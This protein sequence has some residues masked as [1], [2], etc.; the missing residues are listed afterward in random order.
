M[1]GDDTLLSEQEPVAGEGGV[2]QSVSR[3]GRAPWARRYTLVYAWVAM[4]IVYGAIDPS[5]FLTAINFEVIFST[6]A[7]LLILCLG[8]LPSLA[9]G[10]IDLS[11]A[12]TFGLS[13]VLTA[14]LNVNLGMPIGVSILAALALGVLV[15][16]VN[17]LL[18]VKLDVGSLVVTLGMS[19]L[20]AGVALGI[21]TLPISGVSNALVTAAGLRLAGLQLVFFYAVLVTLA[22][23][24]VE[25]FTPLGRYLFFVGA[26][27][28]VSRLSGIPV[29]GLRAG[30]LIAG[31]L[32]ASLAGVLL[33][34]T[35]GSADPTVGPTYLLPVFAG[36]FLGSTAITPG[37]FNALGTFVAIFF[38]QTGTQGLE[39][40][41]QSGWVDQA[42][43]GV[44]LVVAVALPQL[45]KR[46]S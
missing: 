46:R 25:R 36:A 15:G 44:A 23:V 4:I 21:T 41:G 14:V 31:A 2:G 35:Q 20:L 43:Y 42:F 19:S 18:I 6:A 29:Q 12:G 10:E 33:V 22:L 16:G 7:P 26:S 30:T 11:I 24:Y 17:A 40:L 13:G 28:E 27:R 8:L 9:A 5:H 32:A 1:L 38:L 39:L 34:G 3:L 45:L 37:R